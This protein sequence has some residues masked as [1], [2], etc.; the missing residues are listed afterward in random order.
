MAKAITRRQFMAQAASF[1]GLTTVLPRCGFGSGPGRSPGPDQ[2]RLRR[3]GRPNIILIMADDLGYGDVGCY[4]CTDIRTPAINKLAT[5]GVRFTTFYANAPECTPTRAALLT[6]RYQHRIGGLECAIGIGNVGR[7][8]DAVRLQ[9]TNDL[10]LPVEETSIARILKDAGYA[11]A[12]CGKWHL[13]YEPKFFPLKHGFDFWFG[14]VGGAVDYFHHCEYTGKPALYLNDQPIRR[15][16][17]LTDLITEEA[18]KFIQRQ[19]NRPFF[20][21]VAY[22]APHTPYQGPNDRKPAPVS[23]ADY[24]KGSRATYA[25]MVERMDE[26]IAKKLKTQS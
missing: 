7:Y 23:E 15:Q 4:G 11:T 16:G 1:A 22:T 12:I 17:Y 26:G 21:Y 18:V 24:N 25:S 8:D 14:P 19:R 13:G 9:K 3:A 10:G 5:E 6:G 2:A 20:L